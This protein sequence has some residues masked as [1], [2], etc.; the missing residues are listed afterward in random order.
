MSG[1]HRANLMNDCSHVC[2][3]GFRRSA[4]V[5]DCQN[6]AAVFQAA[7]S[8]DAPQLLLR[9]MCFADESPLLFTQNQDREFRGNIEL[10]GVQ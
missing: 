6:G 8:I 2:D 9:R 3:S 1:R 10:I 7:P 4:V 5:A